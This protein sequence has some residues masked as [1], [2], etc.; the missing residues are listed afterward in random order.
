MTPRFDDRTDHVAAMRA[1]ALAAVDPAAAVRRALRPGDLAGAQRVFLAGAGKAGVAMAQAAAE[2]AGDRL[3]GGVLSVP[4]PPRQPVAEG[5]V[6]FIAGGHPQPTEGSLEAGRAV[7]ELLAGA[8]RGDLVL[9]LISGGASALLELPQ[10]GITLADLRATTAA[11]LASGAAIDE[12]NLVRT[13]LSQIKGGGLVR[14]AGPAGVLGLILSDVVGNPLGSIGSGPSV[15][16]EDPG[17]LAAQARAVV[18]RYGLAQALPR[19][20][21][22]RLASAPADGGLPGAGQVENRLIASNRMAGEAAVAKARELG[23]A[24]E[25]VADDWQ[26]EARLAGQRL[27]ELAL[28]PSGVLAPRCL[29]VGGETTVTLRGSGKGGRNQEVAL[30]AAI[31]IAGRPD[32]AIATIATD[33]VDG[34]TDA[35]GALVTG[36][37]VAQAR[38]LG[39]DPQAHLDDNNTY[40]LLRAVGALLITGPTGTNVNDLM[41]VLVYS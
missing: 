18:E 36:E 32:L 8:A 35:A 26:G 39:L 40:P 1:A 6:R 2:L 29:V 14:L 12:F 41:V 10:P 24:A 9:A 25:L 11:L 7:A 15:P 31:E 17:R 20:V 34:P 5:R 16:P 22:A 21:L 4:Q 33:G 27:A 13:R 23:F 28:A 3:A 37:T 38:A 19:A 30:A